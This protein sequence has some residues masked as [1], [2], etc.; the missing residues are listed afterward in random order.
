MEVIING[1]YYEVEV[2]HFENSE[3][4]TKFRIKV[5][6]ANKAGHTLSNMY[7]KGNLIPEIRFFNRGLTRKTPTEGYEASAYFVKVT[8]LLPDNRKGEEIFIVDFKADYT[9]IN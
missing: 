8:S 6:Q 9:F 1:E 5:P 4:F 3:Y 2:L 7:W